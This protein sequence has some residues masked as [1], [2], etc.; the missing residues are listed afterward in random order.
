MPDRNSMFKT[1]S[2]KAVG[3]P[4]ICGHLPGHEAK[5]SCDG[6]VMSEA[7]RSLGAGSEQDHSLWG[8]KMVLLN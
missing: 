3:C 7:G 1:S 6:L 8:D 5:G 4:G 2:Y